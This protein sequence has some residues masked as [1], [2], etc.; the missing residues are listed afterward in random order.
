LFDDFVTL[1]GLLQCLQHE[2][3][4]A[5][6]HQNATAI[7]PPSIWNSST[8]PKQPATGPRSLGPELPSLRDPAVVNQLRDRLPL[9]KRN[10]RCPDNANNRPAFIRR[11][12]VGNI[13]QC[14][15]GFVA[16]DV[17]RI[18]RNGLAGL[19]PEGIPGRL[20]DVPGGIANT[21]GGNPVD[22]SF[23]RGAVKLYRYSGQRDSS[24]R[25]GVVSLRLCGLSQKLQPGKD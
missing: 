21:L 1:D 12:R 6:P 9:D 18:W 13:R 19:S 25:I 2:R 17:R 20:A 16:V 14:G 7:K 24:K 3:P 11:D 5:I 8:R 15:V 23:H 22:P 10:L 4:G